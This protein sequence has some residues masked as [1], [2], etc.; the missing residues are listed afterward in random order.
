MT[1]KPQRI[2]LSRA[3]GF[4]LTPDGDEVGIDW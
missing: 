3:D 2:H 1:I 4:Y